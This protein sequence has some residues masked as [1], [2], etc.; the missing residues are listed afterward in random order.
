MY[1]RK[2]SRTAYETPDAEYKTPKV[3]IA[4]YIRFD[5]DEKNGTHTTQKRNLDGDLPIF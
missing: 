4:L 5:D 1:Y 2:N 3:R